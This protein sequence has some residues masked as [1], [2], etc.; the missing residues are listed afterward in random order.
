[1]RSFL[2][3]TLLSGALAAVAAEIPRQAPEYVVNLP[4]GGHEL[5]SKHKGKVV[6]MEFLMTT[7]PHCQQSAVTLSK[8]QREYGPKV[9]VLGVA[10]NPNPDIAGFTRQFATGF[11]VGSNTRETA[12]G[13]LQHSVMATNFYVPQMV[14]IDKKGVIRAQYGGTDLFL[15]AAQETNIRGLI[16]KLLAEPGGAKPAAGKPKT[17]ARPKSSGKGAAS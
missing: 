3:A 10:I 13:F 11:T 14:F 15:G 2:V 8:L 6:V 7:C 16:D 1:M 9:Q 12:L 5:L 4:G 17:T